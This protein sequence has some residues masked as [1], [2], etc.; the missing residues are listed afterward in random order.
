MK[1]E[2]SYQLAILCSYS[3]NKAKRS[4]LINIEEGPDLQSP[5]PLI[6]ID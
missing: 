3:S 5:S 1:V 4:H 6:L 2:F